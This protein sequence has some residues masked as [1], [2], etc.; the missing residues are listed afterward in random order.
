MSDYSK[1][2]E[3]STLII[4]I[5]AIMVVIEGFYSG[6]E[7]ALL[8]ADRL[9][10]R[11]RSKK[12]DFGAQLA[13][14]ML[15]H[16]EQILSTTLVMTSTT[17]MA[18]SVALTIEFRRL[19]G[20]HGEWMAVTAGSTVVILFGE[21]IPKFFYRKF[22]SFF[23]SKV[24]IPIFYTQKVLSPIL[25]LTNLY[26]SQITRAIQP[27]ERLWFGKN[28]GKDD[29]QV[30]LTS[31][32][33][34]T[35]ISSNEKRLIKKIL[36]FRD[37]IAKDGYLPLVK[38]DAV[39]KRSS[40][41][42]AYQI[43][44]EKKHSRL[45]V[46]DDRIDNIVGTLELFHVIRANDV[47]QPVERFIKPTLYVAETQKLEDI[48]NEMIHQDMQLAIVVDEYGGAVGILT[49]E[50]IF[51][52]IV[53]DLH[54][55]DDPESRLI[56]PAGDHRWIVRANTS[57]THINE[58]LHLDL[59]EGDYDT[60]GGFLLRQFSR[61]PDAGDELFFD[62]RAG[63]IHFIVREATARRIDSVSIERIPH[64]A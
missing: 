11:K 17:I 49:R 36:K 31:D 35:Q 48:L 64:D 22:S 5:V 29:L 4:S 45:P 50:D 38:V 16:P 34:D 3:F 13:L 47:N 15:K 39:E 61:I 18:T 6:S 21:L 44:H 56:R 32:S 25:F 26:T 12:G 40:L 14:R 9:Q 19:F 41:G 63:Q 60:I 20:E 37:K 58:E 2:G 46:Y 24:A 54:D 43:F 7:L 8:S 23:A 52:Q 62:T 27:L 53:G 1:L 59:P 42:S 33:N 57:M 51:E 10:L 55:E 28:T 30:L